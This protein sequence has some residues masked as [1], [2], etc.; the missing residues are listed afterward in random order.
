MTQKKFLIGAIIALCITAFL[1]ITFIIGARI[2]AEAH[3]I[4]I[5]F[6]EIGVT[7]TVPSRI[8]AEN[9]MSSLMAAER[10][11]LTFF[12]TANVISLISCIY[13]RIKSY[14]NEWSDRFNT[15]IHTSAII[16]CISLALRRRMLVSSSNPHLRNGMWQNEGGLSRYAQDLVIWSA[17]ESYFI[18]GIIIA[19]VSVISLIICT[20]A[21][22]RLF[23]K[24]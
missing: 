16:S 12:I 10:V 21:F 20:I 13:V 5:A 8:L 11:A 2:F 6:P 17:T 24:S 3:F 15:L 14:Q 18:S 1:G 4:G 19:L 9:I 7:P 23:A 22:K